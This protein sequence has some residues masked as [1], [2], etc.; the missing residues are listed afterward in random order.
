[1][2]EILDQFDK[3]MSGTYTEVELQRIVT[4]LDNKY[5]DFDAAAFY[6]Q[7]KEMM[8]EQHL[9]LLDAEAILEP[10]VDGKPLQTPK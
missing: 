2:F 6:F 9:L 3:D 7:A 8:G 1:M 4:Y 10:V 5:P